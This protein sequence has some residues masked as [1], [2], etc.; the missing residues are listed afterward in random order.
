MS[1]LMGQNIE[2]VWKLKERCPNHAVLN[3]D[4]N[5]PDDTCLWERRTPFVVAIMLQVVL[6]LMRRCCYT[7]SY[8]VMLVNHITISLVTVLVTWCD[9][10]LDYCISLDWLLDLVL[11]LIICLNEA[12]RASQEADEEEAKNLAGFTSVVN[13]EASLQEDKDRILSDI[14]EEQKDVDFSVQVLLAANMSTP[15]LRKAALQ[16]VDITGITSARKQQIVWASLVV[17]LTVGF[18]IQRHVTV[19]ELSSLAMQ[20]LATFI[21]WTMAGSDRKPFIASSFA[22]LGLLQMLSFWII[23]ASNGGFLDSDRPIVS[24][25]LLPVMLFCYLGPHRVAWIPFLGLWL[26]S[27]LGPGRKICPRRMDQRKAQVAPCQTAS[28]HAKQSLETV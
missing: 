9:P 6:G 13:A 15:D 19:I 8:V 12:C 28:S 5:V 14:A 27:A 17:V 26:A 11:D 1:I 4:W 10:N 18:E 21:S 20:A 25:I 7:S 24:I 2:Q 3:I 23:A 22:L 16:G